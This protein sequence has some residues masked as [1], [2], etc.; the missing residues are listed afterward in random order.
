MVVVLDVHHRHIRE[1]WYAVGRNASN[2][3]GIVKRH[4]SKH[5]RKPALAVADAPNVV[6]V[7][8]GVRAAVRL[9]LLLMLLLLLSGRR[10]CWSK[11]GRCMHVLS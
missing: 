1:E 10:R 8:L 3:V 9:L 4:E 2:D 6:V 7:V 11:L 5:G